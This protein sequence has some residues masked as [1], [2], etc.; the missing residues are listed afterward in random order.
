AWLPE[1][2]AALRAEGLT[3]T[4]QHKRVTKT[5]DVARHLEEARV[6]D[7]EEAARLRAALDW[8]T[9][10]AIVTFR[11]RL[12]P[13]GGTKPSEVIEALTGGPPAEGTQY[14]RT[15][16]WALRGDR[17]VDPIDLDALR[18]LAPDVEAAV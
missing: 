14:A 6:V 11:V 4:R 1:A 7:G 10:G 13:D 2:P 9:G 17:V 12:G 18:T 5:I 15:A 8:P 16:L 3:V